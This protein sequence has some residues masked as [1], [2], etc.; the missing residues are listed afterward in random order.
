MDFTPH[1]AADVDRMLAALG[2]DSCEALFA[3]LPVAVRPARPLDLPA[4]LAE[5]EVM[6]HLDALAGRNR[7]L[8]CFAGG[9]I[10]D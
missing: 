9:G 6:E 3:H 5:A 10:Y 8:V 1:T 2:L 7:T 4:P